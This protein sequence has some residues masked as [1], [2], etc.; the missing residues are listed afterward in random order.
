MLYIFI[1]FKD[2]LLFE[3]RERIQSVNDEMLE[4]IDSQLEENSKNSSL[5]KL[6]KVSAQGTALIIGSI[7]NLLVIATIFVRK[8]VI[9]LYEKDQRNKEERFRRLQ[10]S[11]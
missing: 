3:I 9:Y 2:S 10:Y 11:S 6:V 1:G 4:L 8:F 7:T 5:S